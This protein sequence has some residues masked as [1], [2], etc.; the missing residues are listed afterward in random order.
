MCQISSCDNG[1]IQDENQCV[2]YSLEQTLVPI[3]PTINSS[4]IVS[5]E[6]ITLSWT[7]ISGADKYKLE[8]DDLDGNNDDSTFVT[9]SPA[10]FSNLEQDHRY[11]VR[12]KAHN[13]AGYGEYSSY[14][15]F[16]TRED[17]PGSPDFLSMNITDQNVVAVWKE[18]DGADEYR[19]RIYD[20]DGSDDR[21]EYTSDIYFTFRG[22]EA[23][24]RY[25]AKVKAEVNG[26]WGEYTNYEYFE[27]AEQSS[28]S[29]PMD[30]FTNN[31]LSETFNWGDKDTNAGG[32]KTQVK[33]LQNFLN[34]LGHNVGI[35]DGDYGDN[36]YYAVKRYQQAEGLDDDGLV[37][38]NTKSVINN[39]SCD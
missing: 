4:Y 14:L 35:A 6:Q 24:H 3:A 37:G 32:N 10:S 19:I 26:N 39:T 25:K 5:H 18:V 33:Q 15:E 13:S 22:L 38:S 34:E 9:N 31:R 11:R 16:K 27:I 30:N 2:E 7:T 23:G 36:T 29:C 21:S 17:N 8:L 28:A 12:V 20:L 1:Y